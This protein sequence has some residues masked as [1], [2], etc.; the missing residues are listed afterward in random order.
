[1]SSLPK[2]VALLG[3]IAVFCAAMLVSLLNGC[4]PLTA[5]RR[6]LLSAALVMP[7]V[8]LCTRV[9]TSVICDGV[10]QRPEDGED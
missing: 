3:G 9:A 6:A 7:V 4:L 2:N 10:R 1:V 5:A 8:W